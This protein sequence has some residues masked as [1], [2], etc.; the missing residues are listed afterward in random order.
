MVAVLEKMA[1][2]V[3]EEGW[4]GSVDLFANVVEY[5]V[6]ARGSRA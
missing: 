6:R 5:G 1:D 3:R 2:E 4:A